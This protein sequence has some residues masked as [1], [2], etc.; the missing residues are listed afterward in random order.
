M[1]DQRE[2]QAGTGLVAAAPEHSSR[3]RGAAQPKA[4]PEA[5]FCSPETVITAVHLKTFV[6]YFGSDVQ[7]M[8]AE[9]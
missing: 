5:R 3:W 6:S 1:R 9:Q 8:D 4:H 7:N 2:V